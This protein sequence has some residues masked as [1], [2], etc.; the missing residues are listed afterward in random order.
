MLTTVLSALGP[1]KVE[2]LST[3]EVVGKTDDG[4]TPSPEAYLHCADRADHRHDSLLLSRVCGVGHSPIATHTYPDPHT[5][6]D[7]HPIGKRHTL[8]G[9][10]GNPDAIGHPPTDTH[11]VVPTYLD[12]N[13]DGD[14]N[15]SADAN[16]HRHADRHSHRDPDFDVD[17]DADTHAITDLH[18]DRN[19]RAGNGDAGTRN[20]HAHADCAATHGDLDT[21]TIAHLHGNP[22]DHRNSPGDGYGYPISETYLG[23]LR[24]TK[25]PIRDPRPG[26][27]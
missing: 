14:R 24:P 20:T 15:P 23:N 18:S 22:R 17:S 13:T 3:G 27:L 4:E 5:D 25:I 19:T 26:R 1:A 21:R 10:T 2:C 16:A 9:R 8:R 12:A 6:H 7:S 11:A